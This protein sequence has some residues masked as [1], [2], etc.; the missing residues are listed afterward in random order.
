METTAVARVR[1]SAEPLIVGEPV[2]ATVVSDPPDGVFF[3]VNAPFGRFAAAAR[4]SLN[5]ITSVAPFTVAPSAVG[6]V[7]SPAARVTTTV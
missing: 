4:A 7:V 5:A 3:T 2:S 6:A 1:V